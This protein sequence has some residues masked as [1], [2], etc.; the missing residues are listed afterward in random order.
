[1]SAETE[2]AAWRTTGEKLWATFVEPPWSYEVIE[3]TVKVDV[4][5]RVSAYPVEFGPPAPGPSKD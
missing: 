3:G 2:L 1:M 4:M 5:G